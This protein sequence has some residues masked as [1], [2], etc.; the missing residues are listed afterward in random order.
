MVAIGRPPSSFQSA[1]F[2]YGRY[3]RILEQ[4]LSAP[5]LRRTWFETYLCVEG[6]TVMWI[7]DKFRAISFVQNSLGGCICFEA[8][9]YTRGLGPD[10]FNYVACNQIDREKQHL[11]DLLRE[12]DDCKTALL[13]QI[14]CPS[15]HVRSRRLVVEVECLSRLRSKS[16]DLHDGEHEEQNAPRDGA[17]D[18]EFANYCANPHKTIST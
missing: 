15:Q 7:G 14:A 16:V 9:K 13:V 10:V 1:G 3:G 11:P 5:L 2:D 17:K 12:F 6:L 4:Y 18:S 8:P